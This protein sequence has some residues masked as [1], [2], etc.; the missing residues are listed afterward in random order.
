MMPIENKQINDY[1]TFMKIGFLGTGL[2]G[3]PLAQQL[4]TAG[5]SLMIYNRTSSRLVTFCSDQTTQNTTTAI[6]YGD[7]IFLMLTDAAAIESVLM[8]HIDLLANKTVIQMGTIAPAESQHFAQQIQAAGGDYL[9]APVLGSIPEAST[10]QL[11]IMAGGQPELF[12]RLLPLLHIL[13]PQP[14]LIGPVGTAAALKLALN[15][16][17][18]TLTTGFAQSL[19]YLQQQGVAPDQFMN[20]LRSSALYA[21]TFDKKL[22][23]M[24]DRQYDHPNFPTKHLAKDLQLFANSATSLQLA[25]VQGIQEILRRAIELGTA[26]QDYAALYEAVKND[27]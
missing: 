19:A 20:I 22:N 11:I 16:M 15:Q 14:V 3:T 13:G 17:I 12:D 10:G 5:N 27:Q 24:I 9:E 23:R 26:D 18:A 25:G 7:Y 8:P 4:I 6:E 21:P 2:M 1:L